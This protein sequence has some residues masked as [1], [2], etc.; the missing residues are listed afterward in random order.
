M[1]QA[2]LEIAK[3]GL[4]VWDSKEKNKYLDELLQLEK[5]Y[6]E[7]GSKHRPDMAIINGIERRMQSL[8]KNLSAQIKR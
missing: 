1:L 6:Y 8:S 4:S 7:E 3:F 2:V 5:E